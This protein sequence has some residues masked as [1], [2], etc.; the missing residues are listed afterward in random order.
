LCFSVDCLLAGLRWNSIS[1][2]L[3]DSQLHL[4]PA[5]RESTENHDT[6][7]LLYI[8]STGEP[9]YPRIQYPLFQ[10]SAVGRGPKKKLKN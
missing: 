5:N 8:Y 3:T 9:P 7:L 1:T 4:K 6:Y 10:L 2:R